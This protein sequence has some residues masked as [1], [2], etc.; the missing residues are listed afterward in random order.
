VSE[1]DYSGTAVTTYVDKGYGDGFWRNACPIDCG[2]HGNDWMTRS[3]ALAF[4]D[5]EEKR[6]KCLHSP[7]AMADVMISLEEAAALL[8]LARDASEARARDAREMRGQETVEDLLRE[9]N[10]RRMELAAGFM[11]RAEIG[12]GIALLPGPRE[13]KQADG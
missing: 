10:D 13:G 9:V 8:R 12:H 11:R 2:R 3:D 7:A 5:V 1:P 6:H 4:R